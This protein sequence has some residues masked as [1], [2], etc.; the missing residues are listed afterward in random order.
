ML[1][2]AAH[3]ILVRLRRT[4]DK[5]DPL[6]AQAEACYAQ[7]VRGERLRALVV[8]DYQR[9]SSEAERAELA[10]TIEGGDYFAL[11]A[12]RALETVWRQDAADKASTVFDRWLGWL[13]SRVV[14]ERVRSEVVGDCVERIVEVVKSGGSR[15]A[16]ALVYAA[17]CF[18]VTCEIIRYV[19]RSLK[20]KA[21]GTVRHEGLTAH[22][23][24]CGTPIG[25]G[26]P[27]DYDEKITLE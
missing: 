14:P 24:E 4:I 5:E 23:P 21:P 13:P 7:M 11:A 17:T 3:E 9:A 1:T 12:F 15:W 22:C 2:K 27:S 10:Q 20:G 8:A 26:A 18:V 16:I 19:V 25:E 6:L